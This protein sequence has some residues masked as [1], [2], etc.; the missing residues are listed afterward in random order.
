MFMF[1]YTAWQNEFRGW[2]MTSAR[3][4]PYL[5]HLQVFEYRKTEIK[6][7]SVYSK[8]LLG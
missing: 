6:T 3:S 7:I 5:R 8:Y 1:N 4:Q 2:P